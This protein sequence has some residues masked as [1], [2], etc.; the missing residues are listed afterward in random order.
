MSGEASLAGQRMLVEG[1]PVFD[2]S[3]SIELPRRLGRRADQSNDLELGHL[4]DRL[5]GGLVSP[6]A[7][8]VDG[9]TPAQWAE[10]THRGA[11]SV[12]EQLSDSHVVDDAYYA[13][14][15]P[16]LDRQLG[17]AGLR[18]AHTLNEAFGGACVAR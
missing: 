7:D 5:E 14:V 18:L 4:R 17:V 1:R 10:E 12:W 8:G 11:R 3:L 6:A 13:K 15:L 2:P 9:G 16:S